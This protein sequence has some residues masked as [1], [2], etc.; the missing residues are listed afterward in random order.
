MLNR[1]NGLKTRVFLLFLTICWLCAK[2]I[3]LSCR[4]CLHLLRFFKNSVGKRL[5]LQFC[6]DFIQLGVVWFYQFQVFH[7]QVHRN[8]CSDGCQEFRNLD[9]FNRPFYF[10]SEFTFHFRRI[11]NQVFYTTKLINQFDSCFFS[12]TRAAWEVI[13]RVSHQSK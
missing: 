9:I 7:F 5:K 10:F 3:E 6:E 2:Q 13:R 1:F 4:F 8:V 11:L 12:Y